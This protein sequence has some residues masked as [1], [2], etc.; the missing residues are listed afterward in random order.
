MIDNFTAGKAD[1]RAWLAESRGFARRIAEEISG[2]QAEPALEEGERKAGR[3]SAPLAALRARLQPLLGSDRD[4]RRLTALLRRVRRLP[5][6]GSVG[7]HGLHLLH[8]KLGFS[9]I[10]EHAAYAALIQDRRTQ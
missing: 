9:F 10:E 4:V 3:W 5:G 2:P 6:G 1:R 8:N 7:V